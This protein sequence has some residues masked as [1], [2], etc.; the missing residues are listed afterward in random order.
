MKAGCFRF[1]FECSG[2]RNRAPD[3]AEGGFGEGNTVLTNGIVVFCGGIRFVP[4]NLWQ[5]R[6]ARRCQRR[7]GV[8]DH[9]SGMIRGRLRLCTSTRMLFYARSRTGRAFHSP[10]TLPDSKNRWVHWFS[11]PHPRNPRLHSTVGHYFASWPSRPPSF[12]SRATVLSLGTGS[13]ARLAFPSAISNGVCPC[14]VFAFISAP[15]STRN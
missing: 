13:W 14:L 3:S 7:N 5:S 9:R 11:P 15:R 2:R 8:M 4:R 10:C 12:R 6:P 1:I